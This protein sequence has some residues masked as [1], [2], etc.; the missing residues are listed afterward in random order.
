V[1]IKDEYS[2]KQSFAN[3]A[4][5]ILREHPLASRLSSVD[6]KKN[7]DEVIDVIKSWLSLPNNTRWLIIY[8]NYNNPKL[9][10]NTDPIALDIRKFLPESY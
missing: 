8:D 2:L 9:P 6:V 7:L 5:Q 1:N 10:G 3:I 4:R